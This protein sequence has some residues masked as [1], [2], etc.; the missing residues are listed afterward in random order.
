[1][2]SGKKEKTT[3]VQR[4]S[5]FDYE[6]HPAVR[7]A[8]DVCNEVILTCDWTKLAVERYFSDWERAENDDPEFPFYFDVNAAIS[9]I[10]FFSWLHHS[11]GEWAGQTF[12]LQPWQQFYLWQLF[13]W[14][15]KSDKS[16]RFRTFY[17]SV[18]RKNGK[19]T[20]AA[21]L[22][23]YFLDGDGEPGAEVYSAATKF[24]Q[25]KLT[26]IEA[27]RMV[28]SSRF[29]R[30]H[31]TIH[32]NNIFCKKTNSFFRALGRDH[33][34]LDGLNMSCGIVDELHAH[35]TRDL[36]DVLDTATGSRRQPLLFT[37]TTAGFNKYS[38]CYEI[39][40][41]TQQ[42]LEQS[43]VDD[44]FLGGIYTIDPGDDWTDQSIWIKANPSLGVCTKLN[45]VQRKFK[46][47]SAIAAAQ[48]SFMRLHLNMWTE[49][50]TRWITNTTWLTA[51]SDFNHSLLRGQQCCAGL[52]LST[53]TDVS[54]FIL[55]FPPTYKIDTYNV[56]CRFFIPLDNIHK[57]VRKDKV[58]F[59]VWIDEGFVTATPGKV[60]DYSYII[61]Q[62]ERDSYDYDLRTIAFDRWGATKISQDIQDLGYEMFSDAKS[63]KRLQNRLLFPFGQGYKS[64][65]PPMKELEKL[66]ISQKLDH[67]NNPVLTWMCSNVV[68]R[69][70]PAG[71]I[72]PDKSTSVDRIDGIVALIMALD[73]ALKLK[74]KMK[75]KMPSVA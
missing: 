48:N 74:P 6:D 32:V 30:D 46:K 73:A 49:S 43:Q 62:I 55:V 69:E 18:A 51:G 67:G 11:K 42:I 64:M 25:A 38:I 23:L 24:D 31:I 36:W 19:T 59:D 27:E 61:E 65:S 15:R 52:D 35:K 4:R 45:D 71:N 41:Y 56:L 22:G 29:L 28:K 47:A 8:L 54:A 13:G 12:D 50:E 20:L 21:G 72:K 57:R 17:L 5:N 53:T 40:T 10:K 68:T 33:D 60:I 39:H 75:I 7:Y 66:I 58:P 3:L 1:M 9:G 34:S 2:S 37:I 63:K 14:K 26:H 44:T 70:D 16:R